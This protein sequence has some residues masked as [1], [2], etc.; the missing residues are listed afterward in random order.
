MTKSKDGAKTK[1]GEEVKAKV[2]GLPKMP[3]VA[4]YNRGTSNMQKGGN[5]FTPRVFRVTQHKG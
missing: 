4:S 3:P 5:S 1:V 2:P